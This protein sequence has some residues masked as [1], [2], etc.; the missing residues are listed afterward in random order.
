MLATGSEVPFQFRQFTENQRPLLAN[1]IIDLVIV[2]LLLLTHL[3]PS[4]QSHLP[5][6]LL[7]VVLLSIAIMLTVGNLTAAIRE[8]KILHRGSFAEATIINLDD[9]DHNDERY[10]IEYRD[11]QN[12]KLL[13]SFVNY[14]S[15]A[16]E[17]RTF[18][19]RYQPG[20]IVLIVVDPDN[21]TNFVQWTGKYKTS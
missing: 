15:A 19:P 1:I 5:E 3:Y 11:A 9:D 10:N 6:Q 2:G 13:G 21:P 12:N 16:T 7:L 17:P 4:V 8:W 20:D 14:V 18:Q